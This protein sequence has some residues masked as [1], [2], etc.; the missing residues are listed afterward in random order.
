MEDVVAAVGVTL[1]VLNWPVEPTVSEGEDWL[2]DEAVV[3]CSDDELDEI[4]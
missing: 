3:D 2:L 4:C 1:S